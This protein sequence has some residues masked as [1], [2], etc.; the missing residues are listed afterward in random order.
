MKQAVLNLMMAGGVFAPF[1]LA[2]R[3]K[4]VILTYHRFGEDDSGTRTTGR[5]FASQ[6]EYLCRHYNVV[7]LS[8]IA[9]RIA[10]NE[11]LIPYSVVITIDDGYSDAYEI[12]YPLLRRYGLPAT[13]FVVTDFVDGESWIWTDKLRFLA[14]YSGTKEVEVTV[15]GRRLRLGGMER[16]A[17]L[18]AAGRINELLK[19][20]PNVV[21]EEVINRF[22]DGFDLPIPDC[23][24]E[25][26]GAISWKQ[27][28]EM[29]ANQIE[30]GS[31]TVTHPILTQVNDDQLCREL[32]ESKTRIENVL[33]NEARLFCYPNGNFDSRVQSAA[34]RAGYL[35]AVTTR[36]GFNDSNCHPLAFRRID[37]DRDLAHFV[38]STS[39]FEQVKNRLRRTGFNPVG[40]ET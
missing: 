13:L 24:T 36:H 30:I 19:L 8:S 37:A 38:Q 1:R 31:H 3:N 26:F 10:N 9:E 32:I 15:D 34:E 12:A 22:A 17:R 33:G 20:V 35:C 25:E 5:L 39:G 11:E 4:V 18:Q 2:N 29:S 14:L 7:P 16:K 27:A 23:A 40:V 6:L 28:R 21:K